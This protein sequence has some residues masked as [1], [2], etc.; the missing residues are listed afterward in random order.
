MKFICTFTIKAVEAVKQSFCLHTWGHILL[1]ISQMTN[2]YK[3]LCI[4]YMKKE[5]WEVQWYVRVKADDMTF[6]YYLN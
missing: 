4:L 3:L 2:R 6:W 1:N 5:I